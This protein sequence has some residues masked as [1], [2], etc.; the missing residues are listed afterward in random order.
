MNIK[1]LQENL[2]AHMDGNLLDTS[3]Q[4]EQLI[5]V[6]GI[7][8]IRSVLSSLQLDFSFEQCIDL[9]V[10]DYLEY[11][12]KLSSDSRFVVVYNLLSLKNNL[13]IRV[14]GLVDNN[15][16]CPSVVDV[17][18]SVNWYEREAFD[19]FGIIFDGHPDLRRILTDYGFD[20]HPLRKDFLLSGY[21]EVKYSEEHKRVI[22]TPVTIPVREN[23]AK[24][25][26]KDWTS[27]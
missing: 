23:V 4:N 20:G 6:V 8:V 3:I 15:L 10:V 1:D 17:Y 9:C 22:Y 21:S 11:E 25:F 12:G 26:R 19:L 7:T 5:I 27:G 18:P 2:L 13:R 16:I 24:T 14:K